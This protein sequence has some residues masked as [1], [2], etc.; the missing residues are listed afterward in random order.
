MF[1]EK[2]MKTMQICDVACPQENNIE[3]KRLE[4]RTNYRQ[5]VFEIERRRGFKNKVMLLAISA[6]GG[7][8]KEVLKE[9][10]NMFIWFV[11]KDCGRNAENYLY[12]E[13]EYYSE[14]GQDSSK[15][16]E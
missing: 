16:T 4:K 6:I 12:G 1:E 9:L 13:W 3:K 5:L 8:I 2:E 15:L 11:W 14:S 10:E 7:G